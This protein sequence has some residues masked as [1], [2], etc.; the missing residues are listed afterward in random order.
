MHR[1][2]SLTLYHH[3]KIYCLYQRINKYYIWTTINS[4]LY[5]NAGTTYIPY[6]PCF[7]SHEFNKFV[8][9]YVITHVTVS[10]HHHQSNG[11]VERCMRTIK[12][13]LKKNTDPWMSLLIWR[14]IL[15]DGDLKSPAE[16]LNRHEYQSNLPLIRKKTSAQ[17][18]R[19][20]EK[21]VAK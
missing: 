4:L 16:L 12:G 18:S 3:N 6:R 21:P 5:N 20:K 15:I 1:N 14:L 9:T 11:Q 19:H 2:R 10:Q 17:T 7:R 13:L 8:K